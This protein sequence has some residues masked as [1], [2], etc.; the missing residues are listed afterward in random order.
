MNLVENARNAA[1]NV[2]TIR[3]TDRAFEVEDDGRGIPRELMPRV[4]EPRFS[5]TTSGA[6][7]GLAIVRRLVE[8]WGATVT[9]ASTV[10]DGT[11]V[12]VHLGG[13]DRAS[14]T[15]AT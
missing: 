6:G 10:G 7:L 13:D 8:S 14:P 15:A 11:T 2:I 4:F 1:A 9:I 3:V 5:S 12:S